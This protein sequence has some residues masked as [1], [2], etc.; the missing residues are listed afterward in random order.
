MTAARSQ[1]KTR[2]FGLPEGKGRELVAVLCLVGGLILLA[3]LASYHPLDPSLFHQTGEATKARNWIGPFGAE[4]AALAFG[5]LGI[6]ALLAPVLLLG[7]AV[8]HFR[9]VDSERAVCTTV[10]RRR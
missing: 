4:I 2:S 5:F 8:R 10:V 7:A 6:L 9:G 3:S 1:T